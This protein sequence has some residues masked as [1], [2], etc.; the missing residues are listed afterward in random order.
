MIAPRRGTLLSALGIVVSLAGCDSVRQLFDETPPP[1]SST[2]V[3]TTAPPPTSAPPATSAPAAA[4]P[5]SPEDRARLTQAIREARAAAA[6]HRLDDALAAFQRALTIEPRN[7]RVL[8][9]SGL[10]AHEAGNDALAASEMDAALDILGADDG[11]PSEPLR[12]PIAQCLYNRGL[13]HEAQHQPDDARRRYTRSLALRPNATVQRHLDALPAEGSTTSDAP[14]AM[15]SVGHT[16]G[17]VPITTYGRSMRVLSTDVDDLESAFEVAY[18]GSGWGGPTHSTS[19]PRGEP[20][21]TSWPGFDQLLLFDVDDQSQPSSTHMLAVAARASDGFEVA[22]VDL[23]SDDASMDSEEEVTYTVPTISAGLMS[24]TV[25]SCIGGGYDEEDVDPPE[26]LGPHFA[27]PRC[28]YRQHFGSECESRLVLCAPAGVTITCIA[29]DVA[30]ER[31]TEGTATIDCE[32]STGEARSFPRPTG[33][34]LATPPF[35]VTCSATSLDA[36]TC[37]HV[38]G[39][40]RPAVGTHSADDLVRTNAAHGG[41]GLFGWD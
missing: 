34:P 1:P 18:E 27:D 30:A 40:N 39:P 9:E 10:V 37:T 32:S 26:E 23:Y 22:A 31:R 19:A 6:A 15:T 21:P 38:D 4:P 24:L 25:R 14:A 5:T 8:C 12:V 16:A 33:S 13:V 17:G 3:A 41:Y 29:I 35:T 2:T 7:P 11:S 36:I 20:V 28:V